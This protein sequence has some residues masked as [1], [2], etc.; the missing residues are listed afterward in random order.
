MGDPAGIGPEVLVRALTDPARRASA[1]FLI[2]GSESAMHA[3]AE[4]VAAHPFWWRAAY[5]PDRLPAGAAVHDVLVLDSP[6]EPWQEP[7]Q[8]ML[9]APAIHPR[10]PDASTGAASFEWVE[11]AIASAKRP[12]GHDLHADAIVTAPISK[13]A[14]AL[15]GKGKW[16][17]HTEL[18]TSR[19]GAKVAR[20]FFD[21]P[22]LR[23]ILA[24]AHIPLMELRSVLTIGR[25]CETIELGRQAL[26]DLGVEAP[27][28]AVCGLNPHAGEQGKFGDEERRIIEP[29]IRIAQQRGINATGPHPADT[30]F[31]A[32]LKGKH[33]LVVAMYHD[34]GLIP[35]KLL[36]FDQAVNCTVGLPTIRTSPDHGTASDIAWKGI[37]DPGSMA[38]AIDLAVRM[39]SQRR[40]RPEAAAQAP[41]RTP[42]ALAPNREQA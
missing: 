14:W 17:G 5:N 9:D 38:A 32:A 18:L 3:A 31:N 4:L 33:D 13:H 15:A 10:E 41:P 35:V 20:M 24:T 16:P 36:A 34:Q 27:R 19:L 30:V 22:K 40:A 28:I 6:D 1:R 39:A 25:V 21:S 37:A 7:I 2:H 8:R 23:V 11:R 42:S 12:Q 29:A 26:E